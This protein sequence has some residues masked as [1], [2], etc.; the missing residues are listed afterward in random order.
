MKVLLVEDDPSLRE[1]MG[2]VIADLVE[3]RT[4][5]SVDSALAALGEERFELV[6]AD[7]RIGGAATG[8][9]TI[10]EAARKRLQPVAIVSASAQ[11]EILRALLPFAADAILGKPFQLEEMTALVERF[12]G[13]R[14]DAERLSKERPPESAWSEVSAGVHVAKPQ[15][16]ASGPAP[17]WVRLQPGALGAWPLSPGGEGSLLIEGELEVAGERQTAP[18]YFFLSTGPPPPARTEQGCLVIS[19]SLGR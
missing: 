5:D 13:L 18:R 9:R 12:L 14:K 3:V 8:G 1:G 4:A 17:T 2:E 7:L 11:E 15:A 6:L 16:A 10:L 19:L